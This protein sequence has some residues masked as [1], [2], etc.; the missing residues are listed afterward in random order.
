MIHVPELD[1]DILKQSLLQLVEKHD[2]LR[3]YYPK[4]EDG[5]FQEYRGE[6]IPPDLSI[7]DRRD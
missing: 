1:I 2:A 3:L 4:K 6:A 5:Y 7:L